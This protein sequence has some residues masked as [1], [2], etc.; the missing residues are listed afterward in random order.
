MTGGGAGFIAD[1]ITR[2]KNNRDLVN[3]K[4]YFKTVEK[5]LDEDRMKL[6]YKEVSKKEMETI[7]ANI[8]KDSDKNKRAFNLFF[9]LFSIVAIGLLVWGIK[10]IT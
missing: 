4:G 9:V 5:Y 2:M 7:K 1:M 6:S 10:A 3:K 8:L